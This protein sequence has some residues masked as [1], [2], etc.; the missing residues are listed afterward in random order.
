[1]DRLVA[2]GLHR[3]RGVVLKRKDFP[4]GDRMLYLLLE[5]FGLIRVVAPGA[6]RGKM[7]FGG[8]TE[9]LVW[10]IFHLYRSASRFYL[11]DV[12]VRRDF[13]ELR[14]CGVTMLKAAEW[15]GMIARHTL[16][17]H[18][19]NSLISLFFWGLSN[20]AD[21]DVPVA[22]ADLRFILKWLRLWGLCPDL[23]RCAGC[24]SNIHNGRLIGETLLCLSCSPQ[25][26]GVTLE[27]GSLSVLRRV[28]S[29]SHSD[30]LAWAPGVDD[31]STVS[32]AGLLLRGHFEKMS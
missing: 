6:A 7:R 21:K 30:F 2:Q 26:G 32:E 20:L 14:R 13:L 5:D 12:D 9:P 19:C 22:A 15:A 25:T 31:W 29:L 3:A 28:L 17:G 8:A 11:R 16:E 23:S 18:E 1:M 4:G 10:G 27:N 24:G